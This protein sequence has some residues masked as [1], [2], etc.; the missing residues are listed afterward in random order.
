MKSEPSRHITPGPLSQIRPG[1]VRIY[2][3]VPTA[4]TIGDTF[5]SFREAYQAARTT[6]KVFDYGG[7]SR[8]W[9]DVRV[10]DETGDRIVHR[11]EVFGPATP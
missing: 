5:E 6:I 8:A 2:F 4:Y 10:A 7:C 3:A 9:V 1:E 11:V